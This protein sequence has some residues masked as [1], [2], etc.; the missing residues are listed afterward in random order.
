MDSSSLVPLAPRLSAVEAC[1]SAVREAI[2]RGELGEGARLPP[3]RAL[4]ERLGVNRTTLRAAL[5]E[6]ES[7]GLLRVKQGSGYVV[8]P[9]RETAGPG[10]VPDLVVEARARGE[11]LPLC[12]DLLDVRRRLA[13]AVIERLERRALSTEELAALEERVGRF[14]LLAQQRP[15]ASSAS[16]AAADVEILHAF[17]GL[18]QSSVLGLFLNPVLGVLSAL[19][20]LCDAIYAEPLGNVE[21]YRALMAHL[22]ARTEGP[23]APL[24][25]PAELAALLELRDRDTLARLEARLRGELHLARGEPR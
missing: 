14:S 22:R 5:R 6:L 10:L 25:S 8:R 7:G 19:P 1:A 3:E 12:N 9:W 16:L 13:A 4:S 17:V 18:S 20:E 11:L 23:A 24:L 2:L 15:Q 21:G